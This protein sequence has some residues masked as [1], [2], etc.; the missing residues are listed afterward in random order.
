[1][2][3]KFHLLGNFSASTNPQVL[4]SLSVNDTDYVDIMFSNSHTSAVNSAFFLTLEIYESDIPYQSFTSP[5]SDN[6]SSLTKVETIKVNT[7]NSGKGIYQFSHKI[8]SRFL[9]FRIVNDETRSGFSYE[10]EAR[11]KKL[12]L[13]P[14][15]YRDQLVNLGDKTLSV[16]PLNDYK[17]DVQSQKLKGKSTWNMSARGTLVATEFL[18]QEPSS[19]QGNGFFEVNNTHT[20]SAGVAVVSSSANDNATTIL[21]ARSVRI[22]G[23]NNS[24]KEI[25]VDTNLNGVSNVNISMVS[26]AFSEINSMEVLEVNGLKSNNGIIFGFDQSGSSANPMCII[27]AG[28]S[29]SINPQFCVPIGF[30]VNVHKLSIVSHMEDEGTLF[31]KK[32]RWNTSP[33]NNVQQLVLKNYHLHGSNAW[34][35]EV[36][37]KI[38]E[39]ERIVL[40]GKTTNAP[41]GINKVSVEMFGYLIKNDLTERSSVHH[42]DVFFI[43]DKDTLPIDY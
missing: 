25:S 6:L 18:L 39:G 27:P 41:T 15:G 21:G 33:N 24:L 20:N 8:T 16:R 34:E 28:H 13:L 36:Q 32:Y 17:N 14:T 7:K 4:P 11:R 31:V 40:T 9:T 35:H 38:E 10:I 43:K 30:H 37:F 22:R 19:V 23:L 5:A 3:N 1:M 12:S 26:G 29:V 2:S 42:N